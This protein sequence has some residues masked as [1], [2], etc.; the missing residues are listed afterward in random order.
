MAGNR[1]WR[2]FAD[3]QGDFALGHGVAG[4][5]VHD[6]QNLL[7][8]VA[9][10][11]GDGRCVGCALQAHQGAGVG[12]GG[13][14]DGAAHAFLA[15]NLLDEFLHLAAAFADQADDDDFGSV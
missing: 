14:D 10:I 6:Q 7:A 13:D 5:R 9:E 2:R 12:R 3:G 8:L 15:E 4:E 1:G 11:F